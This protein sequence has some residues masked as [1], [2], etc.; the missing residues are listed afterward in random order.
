MVIC[1][2]DIEDCVDCKYHRE[3]TWCGQQYS[4]PRED[5]H[6]YR[7]Y[8]E[9]YRDGYDSVVEKFQKNLKWYAVEKFLP[10]SEELVIVGI[11]DD[12][13]DKPYTYTSA[14]WHFDGIWIVDGE[15]NGMVVKWAFLPSYDDGNKL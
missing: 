4:K 14:G 11:Y 3:E 5:S 10:P 13:G 6:N 12:R 9:G 1:P 7:Y 2:A 8:M 15:R